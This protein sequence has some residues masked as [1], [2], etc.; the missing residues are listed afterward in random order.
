MIVKKNTKLASI[1]EILC[2]V[3]A[4]AIGCS[5]AVAADDSGWYGGF[6][7]GASRA[8]I[9]DARI[10]RGLARSGFGATSFDND[11]DDIGFKVFGGYQFIKYFA[12]EGGYTDLGKFEFKAHTLPPGTLN[13]ELKIRGL[14]FDT[15]AILP[16]TDRF[17]AFARGGVMYA[18]SKDSFGGGGLVHVLDP[19]SRHRAANYK[20][21]AGVEYDVT[22][23][24]GIRAEA[25]RY[26][27]DDAVGN[28][29]DIDLYSG[30]LVYRFGKETPPA[31]PPPAP[32]VAVAAPPPPV[33]MP[34][35]PPPPPPPPPVVPRRIVLSADSLFAFDK[36]IVKPAGKEELSKLAA[37]LRGA[38][39]SVITV[40]GY[41]DRIG[42]HSYNMKLSLARAEAVKAYLVESAGIPPEKITTAGRDG[43]NPVTTA[44]NCKG[45]KVTN[46]LIAC[47]QP[48]RRVEVEVTGT[49]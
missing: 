1:S 29:G 49:R 23:S 42:A 17:S 24:I 14:N 5:S 2:V 32:P 7:V 3:A 21:G 33:E 31:A 10:S 26:R 25:E 9:D 20:Y 46:A 11:A 37:E 40:T 12:V 27:V 30:G 28:K 8:K 18:E 38:S 15:V 36:A 43:S 19:S 48:D 47:L 16:I 41:S 13:G 44:G 35:P 34:A 45:S 4:A 22:P 39:F 6:N